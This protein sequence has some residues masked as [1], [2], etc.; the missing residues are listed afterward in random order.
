MTDAQPNLHRR[1]LGLQLRS[2]RKAT[3]MSLDEAAEKLDLPGKP[4]LSRIENG[5]QRVQPTA[6][7]GFF[8][9][10]ELE[11]EGRRQYIRQLAKLAASGKRSNLI[12]EYRHAIPDP[13]AEYLDLEELATKSETFAFLIPGLLQTEAYAHAVVES[14]RGWQHQREIASFVELRMARQKVLRR[15]EPLHL[16]CILEEAA[17]MRRV[18]G[19]ALMK[20]QL[21]HLLNVTEELGHVHVQVLL[22]DHGAHTGMDGS[23][24]LLH[25]P[26]GP[27]V[28]VVEPMTTSLY[29]EED[30][31]LARYETGFNHLRGE[32]LPAK[33]ARDY[34]NRVIKERYT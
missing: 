5:K 2:L 12:N 21:Q 8:E 18:G 16:W 13:F 15:Q 26:A 4:S 27:P 33:A 9:V 10:Y 25:F 28:A 20:E 29:L 3:G 11:D 14:S 22:F 32:A 31:H 1:R 7:F 6:I 34:I 19:N 24:H 17:L 23:F 30:K